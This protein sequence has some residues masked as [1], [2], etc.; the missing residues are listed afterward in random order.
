[1]KKSI[2]IPLILLIIISSGWT[3]EGLKNV[4][5]SSDKWINSKTQKT[6]AESAIRLA[7]AENSSEEDKAKALFYIM[8]LIYGRGGTSISEGPKGK[9]YAIADV[10]HKL[11]THI[12][13]C[14]DKYNRVFME[15]WMAHT[16]ELPEDPY[17]KRFFQSKTARK[18]NAR[19][20]GGKYEKDQ[21]HTSTAIY[22]VDEDG[23]GRYHHMDTHRGSFTYC[24]DGSH[25][26][27]PEE[28]Q[29]DV[30][31]ITNP[32]S[33][34]KCPAYFYKF[35]DYPLN[36]PKRKKLYPGMWHIDDTLGLPESQ[37]PPPSRP[38]W[39][40][41]TI[42][43]SV[44]TTDF[45]LRKGEKLKRCWYNI[46]KAPLSAAKAHLDPVEY[47][48]DYTE[49]VYK[50]GEPKEPEHYRILKPYLKANGKRTFGNAFM[51]YSPDLT[52]NNFK[53]G[54]FGIPTGLVSGDKD[55]GEP[56][57][58][59][60][61]KKVEGEAVYIMRSNYG[62]AEAFVTGSYYLKSKGYIA[63]DISPDSGR[64]WY[65]TF[66]TS[67]VSKNKME[68]NVDIGKGPWDKNKP[69]VFNLASSRGSLEGDGVNPAPPWTYH[70]YKYRVRIRIMA[71]K[72]ENDVGLDALTFK[73]THIINPLMYPTLL[74]GE[75]VL[76]LEGW[77]LAP[78]CAVKVEY[79]WEEKGVDK[80]H[81]AYAAKLPHKFAIN[82]EEKDPG[83]IKC[84]Y[85]TISV[86][87]EKEIAA[88]GNF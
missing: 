33:I 5:L 62:I 80:S 31:L 85:H 4:W 9:E 49:F 48:E 61:R 3:F 36:H 53:Y 2:C 76:T 51:E 54:S 34:E 23:V 78:G 68:L 35:F 28:I 39:Y 55:K 59:P 44:Y 19:D 79:A 29:H 81:I 58:R 6:L 7:G 17:V 83:N 40:N 12:N 38:F 64:T 77:E 47:Y 86:I 69:S 15:L 1:M 25:I 8:H 37:W 57:L 65:N 10:W 43:I 50:N 82:V 41:T 60:I 63:V 13:S 30:T 32:S 88:A 46:G 70:G 66:K 52:N 42:P 27:T 87:D 72:N 74:P 21:L 18:V 45:D 73:S 20:A 71:D 67:K 16:G 14:C 11:H 84:K 22:W 75:N 26:A 56:V 24:R